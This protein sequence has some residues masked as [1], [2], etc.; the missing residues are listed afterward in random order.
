MVTDT[1]IWMPN[2]KNNERTIKATLTTSFS[3]FGHSKLRFGRQLPLIVGNTSVKVSWV[4][5][6]T[7]LDYWF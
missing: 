3:F 7:E 1:N 5:C 2:G 6:G 4:V